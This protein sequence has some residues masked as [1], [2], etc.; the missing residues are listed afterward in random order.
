[1]AWHLLKVASPE[2]DS[3]MEAGM[4][5]SVRKSPPVKENGKE[6]GL[7]GGRIWIVMHSQPRP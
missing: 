5:P 1:M 7:T 3:E 4:L 6:A 2:T